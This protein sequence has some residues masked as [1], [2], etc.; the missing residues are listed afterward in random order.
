MAK[1]LSRT[2][3]RFRSDQRGT[4]LVEMALVVPLTL[5]LSAG[6]FEF[7]NLIHDKLLMEAGLSDGARFAARCNS[8]LYTDAGLAAI[9]CAD[10]AKNIAVFGN[11]AGTGAARIVGW[12]KSNVTINIADSATCK[13]A[14][15]PS[16]GT[17]LYLS[18]TS[19]VCI[20]TATGTYAYSSLD[21]VGLLSLF[22]M[23]TVTLG[24]SHQERLIR[25]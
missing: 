9:D 24:A 12:T 8:Q 13:D 15:D 4:A 14:V 2:L 21:S 7:G 6:V 25:F 10:L 19:K 23:T 22:N 5:F 18:T 16:T 17:V 1:L 3:G 20:V 11:V